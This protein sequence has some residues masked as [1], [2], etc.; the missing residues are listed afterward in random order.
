ME[1]LDA[2]P[3]QLEKLLTLKMPFGK[4]EG[5]VYRPC[6]WLWSARSVEDFEQRSPDERVCSTL[7]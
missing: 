3:E 1:P 4:Y 7:S 6:F 2:H 5:R